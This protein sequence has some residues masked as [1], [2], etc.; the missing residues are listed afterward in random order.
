MIMFDQ[1]LLVIPVNVVAV[2]PSYEIISSPIKTYPGFVLLIPTFSKVE[3]L[4][5]ESTRIFDVDPFA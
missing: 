4:V 2:V 1:F 5:V 3:K